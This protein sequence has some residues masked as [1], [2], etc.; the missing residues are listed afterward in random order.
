LHLPL[1][2]GFCDQVHRTSGLVLNRQITQI[3]C[4]LVPP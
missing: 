1:M 3:V 4:M 2:P